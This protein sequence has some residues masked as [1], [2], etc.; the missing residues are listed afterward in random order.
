MFSP[1][2]SVLRKVFE[3][4]LPRWITCLSGV[5]ND[6]GSL[7]QTLEGEDHVEGVRFSPDG[8]KLMC[9]SKDLTV[10]VWDATTGT[11]LHTLQDNRLSKHEISLNRSL[12]FLFNGQNIAFVWP[13]TIE[14]WDVILKYR[15]QKMERND[16]DLVALSPVEQ[17]LASGSSSGTVRV[18]DIASGTLLQTYEDCRR[19]ILSLEFSPDGQKLASVLRNRN[20][21]L[22]WDLGSGSS[23]T[24][25]IHPR[26][27]NSRLTLP[28]I[29]SRNGQRLACGFDFNVG[30]WDAES[31]TLLQTLKCHHFPQRIAFL[32]NEQ[33][34]AFW[35][36]NGIVEVW[37]I[38]SG[39]LLRTIKRD[40]K[41][42]EYFMAFSPNGERLASVSH[43]D[44]RQHIIKI[45]GATF[46]SPLSQE[47]QGHD[48]FIRQLVFSPCGQKL[49]SLSYDEDHGWKYFTICLWNV[50]TGSLLE[51]I[52]YP[53]YVHSVVFLVGG[54][55]PA[56][57]DGEYIWNAKCGVRLRIVTTAPDWIND[58]IPDHAN[59]PHGV[60]LSSRW[61][62]VNQKRV[63]W[64]PETRAASTIGSYG[65]KVAIGSIYG[66]VTILDLDPK[67]IET[68][69]VSLPNLG[70]IRAGSLN[71]IDT[72]DSGSTGNDLEYSEISDLENEDTEM[73]VSGMEDSEVEDSDMG[74]VDE[75]DGD[76]D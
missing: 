26:H 61:V 35:G 18:W 55:A 1:S 58:R 65:T 19:I 62:T 21:I 72:S 41:Q 52:Q 75:D 71:E 73:G 43:H 22:I 46:E 50:A 2:E 60:D 47:P 10:R 6:W 40:K 67:L 66:V 4:Q 23:S 12:Y 20:T 36:A 45:W 3:S 42:S 57:F 74:N 76:D 49:A 16:R 13:N 31:R 14:V 5:T 38:P 70:H 25:Q 11:L 29:F 30:I 59:Q 17:K 51:T 34:F 15:I 63:V 7:M 64:L 54:A 56:F 44:W 48:N 9:V 27:E 32:L 37:S 28:L 8:E 68:S 24:L 53:K 33:H 39:S 69:T